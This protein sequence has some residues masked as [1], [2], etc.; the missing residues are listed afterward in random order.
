MLFLCSPIAHS[1]YLFYSINHITIIFVWFFC[2]LPLLPH[3][4]IRCQPNILPDLSI[5]TCPE[6]TNSLN[7]PGVLWKNNPSQSVTAQSEI[8]HTNMRKIKNSS[9]DWR[10]R[11]WEVLFSRSA[12]MQYYFIS[13][14]TFKLCTQ[15]QTTP[16]HRLCS[17]LLSSLQLM[18]ET[19]LRTRSI[20]LQQMSWHSHN[21]GDL[22]STWGKAVSGTDR[23]HTRTHD[24][25]N[26]LGTTK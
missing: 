1:I 19:L 9:W 17:F 23:R 13:S 24:L 20:L 22:C 14:L 5:S 7:N 21:K 8:C 25:E 2:T 11:Y 16:S 6:L 15:T 26:I 18:Q 12:T 10:N 3:Y 4:I